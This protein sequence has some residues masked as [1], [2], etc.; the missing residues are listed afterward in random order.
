MAG[1]RL[2]SQLANVKHL[3]MMR[4]K[5]SVLKRTYQTQELFKY[6]SALEYEKKNEAFQ[7]KK[8]HVRLECFVYSLYTVR[9][10]VLNCVSS[11]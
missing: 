2:V 1:S 7:H 5:N 9:L 11:N 3:G 10:K 6:R 4:A 8:Q